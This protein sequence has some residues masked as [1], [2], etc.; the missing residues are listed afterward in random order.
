MAGQGPPPNPGAQRRRR[1][2]GPEQT[3]LPAGGY[4]GPSP[5]LPSRWYAVDGR[6]CRWLKITRQWWETWRH[7]PQAA[8]FAATDWLHLLE[9]ALLVE[10]FWRGEVGLAGEIRL[11]C[12]KLGATPEDRL[13]LRMSFGLPEV[14]S[15]PPV[16]RTRSSAGSDRRLRIMRAAGGSDAGKAQG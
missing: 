1:N 10:R 16:S 13:R 3:V 12:G 5:D 9:T 2:A 11:R 7:A 4:Y 8:T 6:E 15:D 14:G